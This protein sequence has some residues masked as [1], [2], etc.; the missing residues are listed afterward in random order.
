M[1]YAV[2]LLKSLRWPGA[3]TVQKGGKFCSIYVGYGIKAGDASMNPTEPPEVQ[4]DPEDLGEMPEPTP[5]QAP[6][7]PA[8]PDTDQVPKDE[9]EDE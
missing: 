5:L 7:E 4:R 8:E 9:E 3:I 2:N 1:T 6:Q